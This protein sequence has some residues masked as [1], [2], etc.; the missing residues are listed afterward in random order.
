MKKMIRPIAMLLTVLFLTG[1][2][3]AAR[4]EVATIGVSFSGINEQ[5]DGSFAVVQLDGS[6]RLIQN[7]EVV[8]VL[9]AGSDTVNVTSTER[10]R[11]EPVM[12]TMPLGWDLSSATAEVVP[13]AG[14][15]NY[16]PVVVYAA[17]EA[18]K[19]VE[20]PEETPAPEPVP[21]DETESAADGETDDSE[22]QDSEPE[23]TRAPQTAVS[24]KQESYGEAIALTLPTVAPTV[25]PTP[26]P[27]LPDA[28][29]GS[30]GAS[31]RVLAFNDKNTNGEQGT[32]EE[33]IQGVRIY[34]VNAEN[35]DAAAFA[36]TNSEGIALLGDVPEGTYRLRAWLPESWAFSEIGQET[37]LKFS[38]I[39]TSVE[40]SAESGEIRLRAGE[41]AERGI[42]AARMIHVSGFC[43]L[44][45]DGDGVYQKSETRLSGIRVT[46]EGQKNGL[47]YETS[48]DAEGNW[49]IDRV[50]PGFYTITA[51]APEGMTFTKYSKTGG[52]NRSIFTAE[53]SVKASKTLD[54][55]DKMPRDNQNIGFAAASEI[56]GMCFLDANYNGLYDEG[57]EPLPGVKVTA[58][59]QLQDDEIAVTYSDENGKYTLAGLRGNTYKVRAV[60]P[61]N[62]ADFTRVVDDPLGNHFQARTGRRENFWTNF[63]LGNGERRTVNVGA[64]YPGVLK[65][66]VYYDDDLSSTLSGKE[67]TVSGFLVS[68]LNES[69][70]VVAYDKTN[71][72][73]SYEITGLVPGTY[74]LRATAVR[75]YAFTRTG[76]GSVMLN[77]SEGEGYT[78]PFFLA[79]G[80]TRDGMDMGMIMPGR[81]DGIVFADLNDNGV[82]DAGE[83]GLPGVLVQLVDEDGEAF[84][85]EIGSESSYFF[86]AVMPGRYQIL[87]TLPEE[88]VFAEKTAGG[89]VI[90]SDENNQQLGATE[91]FTVAAGAEVSAPVCGALTLGRIEGTAFLD[92]DGS[93]S[94]NGDEARAENAVITL[95]PSREDLAEITVTTGAD[96]AFVIQNLHPD[97][98]SLTVKMPEGMI[99]SRTDG[100][101]LPLQAGLTEQQVTLPVSM[102]A[103]WTAQELGAVK[104]ASLSGHFW[105][106]ENNN[107]KR[108]EEEQTPSGYTLQ[109]LDEQTGSVYA[110]IHTDDTGA[111]AA[112][113]LIPGSYTVSFALD[114]NTL[115]SGTGDSTFRSE[116][117]QLLMN[118]LAIAEGSGRTDLV[119]GIVRYTSMGGNVWIDRGGNIEA[120]PGAVIMLKSA[121]DGSVIGSMATGETGSYRFDGLMPGSYVLEAELPGGSV[122]VEPED[123]RLSGDISSIASR[124]NG[125]NGTSDP[126]RLL[127][128]QDQM[129]LN[130]GAVLPGRL[131]DY[132]WLDLNGDGLQEYNEPGLPEVRIELV[133]NGE[134]VMETV[135]DAFGFY[136][137]EEI[138]P[139]VYTLRATPPAEVR[140]T[141]GGKMPQMIASVLQESDGT[142]AVSS[143]LTVESDKANYNADLGFV[144]RTNGVLPAAI[145]KT[146]TQDWTTWQGSEN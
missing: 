146:P 72:K 117:G 13:Q 62:G 84:R 11:L 126:I 61:D 75:D 83:Q 7:G 140:A 48:S 76:A 30:E 28:V 19:P 137:F 136:R 10:I 123:A 131:G 141:V 41:T 125:R 23:E 124:T 93:G 91:W 103:V 110:T 18:P 50:R 78:E 95:T 55:N 127:M 133:R 4:A 65:G 101:T 53:G 97:T 134:T 45:A 63:E 128:G 52:S 87:Y 129:R 115:S 143:E 36:E 135:T 113:N 92:H 3:F 51:Y 35:G 31:L 89:N 145:E 58:I 2:G 86:D 21:D 56:T 74:S 17:S 71:V 34:L 73:G 82:Q 40:E 33:G 108:E 112:D 39:D 111:F 132:C 25:V 70:E 80:E 88:A 5:D 15:T 104:P 27:L 12:E 81:V 90:A 118:G 8:A 130:F 59:R 46:L 138:Y 100:L 122:V 121:E 32:Y 96:G 6:F 37:G 66:T 106:D 139:A 20:V 43:W 24:V 68:V 69:G 99:L 77:R 79:L 29:P 107:G 49:Y 114:E 47:F 57:E 22:K 16:I 26:E 67:K 38:C 98:Y 105:L 120:L 85:T 109:V 1:L 94:Q 9:R 102:G 14:A 142:T 42:G 54:T 144:C 44:D 64:I 60:L 119:L 116:N